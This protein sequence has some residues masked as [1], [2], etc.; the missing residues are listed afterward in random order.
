[1]ERVGVHDQFFE[2][3]GHSLAGMKLLAL[4]QK[5][6]GVQLTLKDLFTSPTAAGLAQLIE[7][8]ERKAAESIA[9]AAERETYPVSSPQKRMFVLQQLE[10][11]ETSYNM[12]SVL[13]LK[14]KLDAE[15][16]KS[17]MKQLTERHEAFR[18][19]FD[20]KDGETVQR[21][22]AEA[23][24]DMEYYEA[25]EEDA[26][27]IIQSF[28]RPF[29]LDQLPLVRTGLVKL[30]E[31]DHLLLFDMHHIISDGAS[32]GVLID[33]LSRLYGG[34]TLEPLRIHY[35]DYAVWQQKFIQSE[36]YRKQEEHWLRELDGELPVLTLPADYSRPAVQ[37]FEGDKLVFSLTEE[38]TSALRSLAKQTDSTMYMVLLASYSA[39]LSKLSGQHDIIVG[40]PAAGRSHADLANVIG[41]FV[42]TLALR[43]YPEAD[44]TFTD[45]LKEVKQ[46]AL[47]A[48]D[49]QDYPLEDLLQKVEVQRDTSRNPLF[50]AVFSMQNANAEDLVME[51]IELK[52][53]PFDRKTAKFDLTVTAEDTDE[54]LTFVLEYNTALFKPETAE[55][56]KHYWL[57]LLKA[58]TENPAAK[59]SELSLVNET[60][61]QALLNAWKGKTLSVPRD[62]TVHRLFEETAAR[63]ANRPAAAYN[64]AKWTYG[65]L[66]ARANRIA[67]IL[68]DCGVT[69]DERVGI[70]TKPSLE[71]AAGVLGVL[72]AGAAF[73]PI[74]PDYPQER[75]SYILQDS[76][77]K[78]LL[79]QEALDVPDGYTGETILLDG[80]RSILSLPLDEN[81]EANPQTETTADHLAYMIYTSGTT[82][83]PKGVMVEHHALVNLCFWHH[84]AF[85]MT[86][87]DKSAK[88]AGFGFDASIWEMFPTWTI[89]AELHVIDEAIRLDITRLNH[90]F[91]EHGVTITFLPTQLAEQF[92]ELENTSLR[93]LLVGGDKLKRAV[94]QPY[95]IV[96]NYGP[97]E[98]TVVAT[99]GVI[100]PEE[101]SLSIGRA[102]ANTRAYIL[103]D[104]DQ[105]QPEGIAGELCVAGRGLARGYLNR[106]EETAKRFTAD[107]FVPGERMY[108]T[109]DLVKWN[110]QSGIEYIGRIDQQ[111]KVRGYRIELS[112]IEVRLAQLADVHDAAVTAVEDKAGNTALC[113]YVAPRQDDIE[114]LKA[115]L[116]DTLPDYMVPAFWVEMDELPVTANGKIDKKPCRN[117]T[118][119]REAPLTK[120]RKRRWR[121]CFPTFGRK[122]SVLVRSA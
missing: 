13:R 14:G 1:M 104:G 37:T 51:G 64:G 55:T 77:A 111:V 65:E 101:G 29:R 112:E 120:R 73:V 54:G 113:A 106:E 9:P 97:T 47:H 6:F 89:G 4:I 87:D 28:I 78:L 17:V 69:A 25:S 98:N 75:I 68:I 63:Y 67:R 3:G 2:I 58:A 21:I 12:P 10:G 20:I 110:A 108:R 105:V 80:G 46:T 26:E 117:R 119:K 45:Y 48:F 59:L 76:G 70:L 27:Q 49:A 92:M 86:A 91:E 74:D 19:T 83:Q 5:T 15:K 36:Q 95:T 109:G 56:W 93:M 53:H 62:K 33:E 35:K 39:F 43:T 81:D 57:Q 23:Y 30:A 16:L 66:N 85:A 52:H 116:K 107:P 8:A 24:I 34:E 11:A 102:I 60:E 115:A 50:D 90:Y 31:H 99:S 40:S 84:D 44:K 71:M 18:T 114:A 121:R 79:T 122:C 61:K 96:N 94:K 22:W 32:V 41:V 103:G 88:Y 38:Q 42:N 100:N 82:G 72:K 118:L 7:G